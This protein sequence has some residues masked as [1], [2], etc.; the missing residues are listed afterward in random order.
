MEVN[1]L[2]NNS[3][4]C[5]YDVDSHQYNR[6]HLIQP[7][8]TMQVMLRIHCG[9]ISEA[10]R[11]KEEEHKKSRFPTSS[12]KEQYKLSESNLG[13]KESSDIVHQG[14]TMIEMIWCSL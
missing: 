9:N 14:V 1:T 7:T 8:S 4:C 3:D 6:A 5:P 11:P 13:T 10:K 2:V 12:L